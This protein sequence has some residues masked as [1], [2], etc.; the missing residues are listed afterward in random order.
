MFRKRLSDLTGWLA[1]KERKPLVLRGARQVGKTWLVRALADASGMQLIEL[2][3][4]QQRILATHFDSNDPATILLNLQSALNLTITPS[5]AILF[6]D[7]IQVVP[8]LLAKLRWFYENMPELAVIAAGSL[9]D[10]VLADHQFSMP[11]GRI[12][13]CFIEPLSFE[14]FLIAKDEQHLL[15]A[16]ENVTLKKPLNEAL[17]DKAHHLIK[18]YMTVG[19]MPESVA[20]WIKSASLDDVSRVHHD[21]LNT[22]KNDF[23]KYSGKLEESYLEDVLAA[24][25][26][27][28]TQKMIYR[29][30]N[31]TA[32]NNSVKQAVNLLAE[33]RLCHVVQGTAANGI[34][35]GADINPK[36]FKMIFIDVG[37]TSTLLGL[38][39]YQFKTIEDIMLVN[40]GA[41]AEQLVG[42]QLRVSPS[43]YV[44]PKL[45]YWTRE[46][47]G[48]KSEIDYL[49][50]H[51]QE[52]IPIEVKA[53]SEG[54]LRSLHQFMSEKPWNIAIRFYAGN[55]SDSK[56]AVKTPQGTRVQ[57][58]LISLPFYLTNQL[59][60]LINPS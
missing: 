25:P 21:L 14:E 43:F 27:L 20:T 29:R 17:H 1:S 22:Y 19:G 23:S 15:S 45:Y 7:E 59:E 51:N 18:E 49:I 40:K 37:L 50:Q 26:R 16:I 57:Y 42:Q 56:L 36:I 4:E 39:L 38:K 10:F 35:V 60:R 31:P 13:Y 32:R 54:K 58:R 30:V 53:G 48:A 12:N 5:K 24:V 46:H 34:P 2:N 44:D 41:I 8:E 9:L 3:F 33:A 28:L 11:V 47:Q 6:L 52:I 55:L